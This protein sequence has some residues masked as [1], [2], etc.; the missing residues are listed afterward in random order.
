MRPYRITPDTRLANTEHG[1]EV[2]AARHGQLAGAKLITWE[3]IGLIEG[4]AFG[5]EREAAMIYTA[6]QAGEDAGRIK[7]WQSRIVQK[8]EQEARWARALARLLEDIRYAN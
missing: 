1:I 3:R 7:A 6:W 5:S 8:Q 2:Q 4:L